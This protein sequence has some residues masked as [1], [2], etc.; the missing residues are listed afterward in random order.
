ML[1]NKELNTD[2]NTFREKE[3]NLI[4]SAHAGNLVSMQAL[5]EIRENKLN[6]NASHN[7]NGFQPI[8]LAAAKG[9]IQVVKWLI[10]Q[11][12]RS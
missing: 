3:T 9:H 7:S 8:H 2:L 12:G 11:G 1:P 6:L 5:Y 10:E 4:F